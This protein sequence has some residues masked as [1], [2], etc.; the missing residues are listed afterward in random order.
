MRIQPPPNVFGMALGG[1][2]LVLSQ[3]EIAT[4]KAAHAIFD[5]AD[6]MIVAAG[7]DRD[8]YDV[9]GELLEGWE[10]TRSLQEGIEL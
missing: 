2:R 5:R 7:V 1:P 4:L 10:A 6:R 8:D 3:R 9:R